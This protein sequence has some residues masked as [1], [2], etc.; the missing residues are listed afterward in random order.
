M[1]GPATPDA[2]ARRGGLTPLGADALMLL[3]ALIWGLGFIAQILGSKHLGP[4]SFTGLRFGL[5]ALIL[6]PFVLRGL[7]TAWTRSDL[8]GGLI[9]GVVMAIAAVLQQWG[10]GDTT[11]GNG[12]FITS[13][14]VVIAPLFA[15]MLGHRVR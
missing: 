4:L 13:T 7:R 12:G 8:T 5:A 3:A 1:S 6:A 2:P 15:L 11:A 10:M 9:A 14:Y